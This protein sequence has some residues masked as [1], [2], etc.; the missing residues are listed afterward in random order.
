MKCHKL[1]LQRFFNCFIYN[2]FTA[3]KII[4]VLMVQTFISHLLFVFIFPQERLLQKI[5]LR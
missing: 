5:M 4:R 3:Q 2:N 1:E